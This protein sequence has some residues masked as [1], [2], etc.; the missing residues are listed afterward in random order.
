MNL[1]PFI[2]WLNELPM[3]YYLRES[4]LAFPLTEAIHLIGLAI[5]VGVIMW[6][7]LRML[8]L[9][10]RDIPVSKVISKLEPLAWFGFTVMMLSGIF[11]FLGK[12]DNYYDTIPFK[13]KMFLLPLA[14]LNLLFF[15]TSVYKEIS[16]WDKSGAISWKGKL[17]GGTSLSLWIVITILGR[18]TAYFA[19]PLYRSMQNRI[20]H[21]FF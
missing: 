8:N 9:A 5:S 6:I 20:F 10:L 3:S 7:D 12:P 11:L 1:I 21:F 4:D 17:V 16:D 13:I 19:D 2:H 18:W 14:G 15:H